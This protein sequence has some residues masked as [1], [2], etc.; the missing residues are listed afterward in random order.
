MQ[1]AKEELARQ[2]K[3]VEEQKEKVAQLDQWLESINNELKESTKQTDVLTE[4]DIIRYIE[5]Y[6][7]YLREYE[8]YEII[9][10]SIIV[11]IREDSSQLKE[12]LNT[13]SRALAETRNLVITEIERLR[14]ILLHLRTVPE[15]EV[16]IE[17]DISQTDRT[18]DSTSMPEEIVSPRQP[19]FA[20]M[21]GPVVQEVASQK[22]ATVLDRPAEASQ[23]R[24]QSRESSQIKEPIKETGL[25]QIKVR[26]DETVIRGK[27]T[28]ETQTGKS[29]MSDA[30]SLADKSVICKPKETEMVDVSITCAPPQEVEVQTSEPIALDKE[31]LENIQ[32]KQTISDGHETIEIASRPVTRDQLGEQSLFI[33]AHYKDD[34]IYKDSQLNITHSLPQSF[35]TVMVEPDETT[36]EVIVDADGTKRII[37]KKVRKTLVTRQQVLQTQKHHTQI[38]SSGNISQDQSLAQLTLQGDQGSS[39]TV[40]D[41]GD[42]KHIQYHTYGGQIVSELPG[43]EVSIQEITSKPDMIITMEQGMKPEE[44]LQLAEGEIPPLIQ[45]SS[46]SVTA[47]VQQVTKRIIKTRRRIIRRV[48]IIDGKEHVTE[49]VIEEPDDVEVL[50]EQIPRVS[51]SV[52]DGGIT[53]QVGD[54]TDDKGLPPKKLQEYK[55]DD[56][57][58][59]EDKK[60]L[61]DNVENPEKLLLSDYPTDDKILGDTQQPYESSSR[62]CDAQYQSKE[63]LL[64]EAKTDKLSEYVSPVGTVTTYP[65]G[66]EQSSKQTLTFKMPAEDQSSTQVITNLESANIATVVQKVTR[67][68]TTTR[69]RIIRHIQIIDGKEH[70]TEEVNEEPDE[71]EIVEHEPEYSHFSQSGGGKVR[72]IRVIRN[73]E[74]IDGKEHVTEQMVEESDDEASESDVPTKLM[75]PDITELEIQGGASQTPDS[76]KESSKPIIKSD[77]LSGTNMETSPEAYEKITTVTPF[78]K[79]T[80]I[81]KRI[82]KHIK[83]IDGKEHVTEEVIEEPEEVEMLEGDRKVSHLIQEE[84]VKTKRFKIIRHVELI[85]GKEH[86][87]EKI[88]EDEGDEYIPGSTVEAEISVELHKQDQSASSQKSIDICKENISGKQNIFDVTRNLISSEIDHTTGL[89]FSVSSIEPKPPISVVD[90]KQK[91]VKPDSQTME[92]ERISSYEEKVKPQP[93]L[94]DKLDNIAVT[95]DISAQTP[96]QT[97]KEDTSTDFVKTGA[98]ITKE[99]LESIPTKEDKSL[100]SAPIETS[101]VISTAENKIPPD[102]SSNLI[103]SEIHYSTPAKP[104][105]VL[106]IKQ[107]IIFPTSEDIISSIE[108]TVLKQ[109]EIEN[110]DDNKSINM[111]TSTLDNVKHIEPRV[112][113]KDVVLDKQTDLPEDLTSVLH[114]QETDFTIV[115]KNETPILFSQ[116][117]TKLNKGISTTM[118]EI[119]P[120]P[121]DIEPEKDRTLIDITKNLLESEADRSSHEIAKE[122]KP[123]AP[124]QDIVMGTD[125]AVENPN[126]E[127]GSQKFT[128]IVTR[129]RKRVIKHIKIIDGKEYITEEVI[130][131]PDDVEVFEQEPS[132]VITMQEQGVKSKRIRIIR[133]V[134]IVDGKEKVTEQIIEEPDDEHVPDSTMTAEIDLQISH[135]VLTEPIVIT[136]QSVKQAIDRKNERLDAE[137]LKGLISSIEPSDTSETKELLDIDSNIEYY[138]TKDTEQPNDKTV[139]ATELL[140]KGL[141][142]QD[143]TRSDEPDK[144]IKQEIKLGLVSPSVTDDY[145]IKE[146]E[147]KG[148][149]ISKDEKDGQ[150]IDDE[151]INSVEEYLLKQSAKKTKTVKSEDDYKTYIEKPELSYVQQ[152]EPVLQSEDQLADKDVIISSVAEI[153]PTTGYDVTQFIESERLDNLQSIA[154]DVSTVIKQKNNAEKLAQ[155][156]MT[157]EDVVSEPKKIDSNVQLLDISMSI[158]EIDKTKKVEP[159]LELDL[160]LDE[161]D[162]TQATSTQHIKATLPTEITI[163]KEHIEKDMGKTETPLISA[164][165]I[166]DQQKIIPILSSDSEEPKG[167]EF[168]QEFPEQVKQKTEHAVTAFIESERLDTHLRYQPSDISIV[169]QDTITPDINA[170]KSAQTSPKKIEPLSEPQAFDNNK[171]TVDIS[172]SITKTDKTKSIEPKLE[173]DLKM[174]EMDANQ[175]IYTKSIRSTLP[176]EIA[177]IKDNVEKHVDK[178]KLETPISPIKS[179]IDQHTVDTNVPVASPIETSKDQEIVLKVEESVQTPVEPAIENMPKVPEKSVTPS[180]SPEEIILEA[181]KKSISSEESPKNVTQEVTEKSDTIVESP[182]VPENVELLIK[183]PE[184]QQNIHGLSDRSITDTESSSLKNYMELQ[185]PTPIESPKPTEDILQMRNL[186]EEPSSISVISESVTEKGYEPE[187]VSIVIKEEEPEKKKRQ[188]KR[189]SHTVSEETIYPKPTTTEEETTVSSPVEM[190]EP[191]HQRK[192]KTKKGKKKIPVEEEISPTKTIS[193]EHVSPKVGVEIVTSSPQDESYHTISESSD[194]NT[195]KIVE[196]CIGSSPEKHKD[197]STTVTFPIPVIEEIS[198]TE[199]SVQTSPEIQEPIKHGE[200]ETLKETADT[201][202]QTS[203]IPVS[204]I[205]IQTTPIEDKEVHTQTLENLTVVEKVEVTSS[206]I[207]TSRPATPE[208]IIK[209]EVTTQVLPRDL[210]TPD[211]KFSQTSSPVLEEVKQTVEKETREMQTSPQPT[212]L[213]EEKGT[214]ITVE[215]RETDIQTIKKETTDQESLTSPIKSKEV[216][217]MSIQTPEVPLV[218]RF[219]QSDSIET[220]MEPVV[221][222]PCSPVIDTKVATVDSTQQTSPRIYE[223]ETIPAHAKQIITVD[224]LQQTSPRGDN[225]ITPVIPTLELD[226]KEVMYVDNM[227]QTTPREHYIESPLFMPLEQP[228]KKEITL[229][230]STQQTSPRVYSEDSIST[231]TDEPYE[232]H[233]RAQVSIPQA[234][235][236]FIE[237]EREAEQLSILGDNYKQ[238]RRKPKKKTESPLQSPGSLSDP[239]NAELSLSVTPTSDDLSSKETSSIDEGISQLASPVLIQGESFKITQRPSYSDVVQRSK[240]KSPSP[241][242]TMVAPISGKAR[243]LNTLEKRTQSVTEPQKIAEDVMTVALLEPSVEKSYD[244]LVNK[245]LD[246][247]KNAVTSNDPVKTEKCI[248]TAI[249]TISIWLEEIQYKIQREIISGSKDPVESERTKNVENYIKRLKE[250]VYITE[251]NEEIITLIETL[252]RQVH[253]VNNVRAQSM[254]KVKEGENEWDKFLAE[255]DRLS[256]DVENVKTQ[257]DHFIL[258]EAPTQQKLDDLDKL[259]IDN[260]ANFE[261]LRKIFAIYRKLLETNPKRE[262]PSILYTCSDDTKQAE[263]TINTER[264]RLLQLSSLAEEYEQTLQDFGQITDVAE[265]LLDG[266]IIVSDLDHLHEEIQKHRKFFVNLSHCRA[267]LESLEDNLDSETRAKYSSLHHSLHD[268]ATIIIDRAAGRAQQMTLAASRWSVLDQGM[269]EEQQ[270]L[271]VAQQRIPD[272]TNVTSIDHEQYINLYQS[273]SLDV[274]HHNAK[275]LRLLSITE[276]L[277]GLIFC[278]GLETECSIAL[279]TLLKLQEDVDSRLTRLIAFKENWATYDYL[280]DRIEGWMKLANKELE[281][282]TPENITTTSNLRRFWELKAQHEVH[283]N[284]KNESGVQFDKALEILPISDEMVQ[285]QFFSK[286]EDKWRDLSTRINNIHAS[287][288]Q[289]ISDRD[290]TSGEKLN[291]LEDEMRELRAMLEGLKGVIKSDDELNLYIERL[292]V[293]TSRIDRIQNELGRLSLLPTAESERLGALL[294]QSGILDDQIAEELERSLLLKEKLV[295]VQTGIAR[296]QKSQRRAR[297]TL[298]ECEAAERLGSDVVE[299]ASQNCQKLLEDLSSQW[300]DILALRQALHTLPISL[301]VCVSPVSVEREISALQ[302]SFL[303]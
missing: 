236:N 72:R 291:I 276:G 146:I 230:D 115:D 232:V 88:V 41:D 301:R 40:L 196:E 260:V 178:P 179:M 133:T 198:T 75:K 33:D 105:E 282:L 212:I 237:N 253:A 256:E 235:D 106:D 57:P 300:R 285:R 142:V 69:K 71:V 52:K 79:V 13:T 197:I 9:L 227:Q 149:K 238:K 293:M 101:V 216:T 91:F 110:K 145:Q 200:I 32:V 58:Q 159:K 303:F 263:N 81:R 83:V 53:S 15:A 214:E 14:Q 139:S 241:C 288:I 49:E 73:V 153:K 222:K 287:A 154:P 193:P 296:C 246:S 92:I 191:I 226:K 231:S 209:S 266:K 60:M 275:M 240:S 96:S 299:R 168:I 264:D 1:D 188:K 126:V 233:L 22:S 23:K 171:Q 203:P 166:R 50:E 277:Q 141:M 26:T 111:A 189:K 207:Q 281:Q 30:P 180:G 251:V 211:D 187:D 131:E 174:E 97:S 85:D 242:K 248:L 19:E 16:P 59:D 6:E 39:S 3:E 44:I 56:I 45:T 63:F 182:K 20:K 192:I 268:R 173:L 185:T 100:Q 84:G 21:K 150:H 259:E 55:K 234:T 206:Q 148:K 113:N 137:N 122:I 78:T 8:E 270:W 27:A 68:L 250:T 74:I 283:N 225:D 42:V 289:N 116:R 61:K 247:L 164:E 125:Y 255:I 138:K 280:I 147:V 272:L 202:L 47:V 157:R 190:R 267:I 284:L 5:I 201:E 228:S 204:E 87:T 221:E 220:V 199:Y 135:P 24:V 219:T 90:K 155:T 165:S 86:V 11:T 62:L 31:M 36:T 229:A 302:V 181:E 124:A 273:I 43:S 28:I 82:I 175:T 163:I 162:T 37:V 208:Q 294:T 167:K 2:T 195:V 98:M 261:S 130:H 183:T 278:S 64:N 269:K 290:V 151:E 144:K 89:N 136:E 7:R 295:H 102:S 169:K 160:K 25:S 132:E 66:S 245:E 34:N 46:S 77:I 12:K 244:L 161:L 120:V 176:T 258:S 274:S 265:A 186:S 194:M 18:L 156:S 205:V 29:L 134:E 117:D 254:L 119:S 217:E 70:V 158:A 67:K 48:V 129:T 4:E 127:I 118:H 170:Q 99:T 80:R 215:T 271:S 298:E 252:T 286:I 65:D 218:H 95:Q 103:E 17:E 114:K 143:E 213:K 184:D 223:L 172:M 292:Q 128:K 279:D 51:I 35:E 140:L 249:E 76:F 210:V 54:D 224:T 38:L 177:I 109:V 257:I 108:Q 239:I 297:L 243:L 112:I 262:C 152:F 123:S 121:S 104:K 93:K 10:K 107:D 94:D